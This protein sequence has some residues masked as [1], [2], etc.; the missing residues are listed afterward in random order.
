[1]GGYF[2]RNM[3]FFH[4]ILGNAIIKRRN[5]NEYERAPANQIQTLD[6]LDFDMVQVANLTYGMK[7]GSLLGGFSSKVVLFHD[8]DN[9]DFGYIKYVEIT[10]NAVVSYWEGVSGFKTTFNPSVALE[11]GAAK[12]FATLETGWDFTKV[13][14]VVTNKKRSYYYEKPATLENIGLNALMAMNLNDATTVG[15]QA[16]I[17]ISNTGLVADLVTNNNSQAKTLGLTNEIVGGVTKIG[18]GLAA[19]VK[20]SEKA[21]FFVDLESSYQRKTANHQKDTDGKNYNITTTWMIPSVSLGAQFEIVKN[22]KFRISANPMMTWTTTR[23]A[24]YE[25]ESVLSSYQNDVSAFTVANAIGLGYK[26]G[27]FA[28]NWELTGTALNTL[29]LQPEDFINLFGTFGSVGALASRA[30]VSF[31]F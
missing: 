7:M 23:K 17:N 29:I 24:N 18:L 11:L 9:N 20:A 6:G 27:S 5:L 13:E 28:F 30:Q 25:N 19:R 3:H 4:T 10:T 15:L 12:L 26:L 16:S 31:Y 21:T 22:L 8:S 14:Y 2:E 1:M